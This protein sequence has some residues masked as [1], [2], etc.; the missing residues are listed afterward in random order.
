MRAVARV[1]V[2]VTSP[3]DGSWRV[4]VVSGSTRSASTNTAL[5]RTAPL[6]APPGVEVTVF[7][8]CTVLPHFNP[9]DDHEPLPPSVL[10]LRAAIA[11]ADA[12]LFCTP[13]Y[14]GSVPGSLKN[15][16]DWV[17]GGTEFTGKPTAWVKVATDARRG[18]GAHTTLATV[19]RYVQAEVV[20]SACRHIPI[21]REMVGPDGLIADRAAREAIGHTLRAVLQHPAELPVACTLGP[22]D[23]AQR[24]QR[25]RELVERATPAIQRIGNQLEVQFQPLRGA[26]E[27]LA[28]LAVAEQQCCAF[29]TWTVGVDPE[30]PVLHVTA[31]PDQPDNIKPIIHLFGAT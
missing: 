31:P 5:C 29:L 16:L 9:D 28:A 12:V 2:D 27:E 19:L 25:W 23:G 4:L 22:E 14:A 8:D 11:E 15:L 6:C 10:A 26:H 3:D 24:M 13:E 17:V 1:A 7:D 20:A 18:E 21:S 30:H